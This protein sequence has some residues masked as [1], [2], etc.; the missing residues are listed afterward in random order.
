MLRKTKKRGLIISLLCIMFACFSATFAISCS[1]TAESGSLSVS[2]TT[3]T[4]IGQTYNP[5]IVANGSCKILE[6]ELLDKDFS[7]V[8][9]NEED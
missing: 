8:E 1:N 2:N 6:V 9:F 5:E 4:S 7:E 3:I